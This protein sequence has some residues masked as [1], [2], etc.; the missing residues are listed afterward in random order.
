MPTFKI[1]EYANDSIMLVRTHETGGKPPEWSQCV[2]MQKD[3]LDYLI[4]TLEN[5]RGEQRRTDR[6]Q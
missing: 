2:M 1:T 3:E 6:L 4:I 5:Y